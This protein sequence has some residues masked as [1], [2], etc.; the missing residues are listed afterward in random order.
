MNEIAQAGPA[1][2]EVVPEIEQPETTEEEAVVQVA[3]PPTVFEEQETR[4][5][6]TVVMKQPEVV[7]PPVTLQP[8]M[9]KLDIIV[10]PIGVGAKVAHE[11]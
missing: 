2:V 6:V 4:A 9:I 11:T 1:V 8:V 3:M 5:L 7:A 10:Q